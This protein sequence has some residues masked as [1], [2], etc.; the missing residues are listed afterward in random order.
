MAC[1]AVWP[2]LDADAVVSVVTRPLHQVPFLAKTVQ[3]HVGGAW[4]SVPTGAQAWVNV[5]GLVQ[6]AVTA[7]LSFSLIRSLRR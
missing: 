4:E 6:S 7:L 3:E 1:G 5:V 2:L